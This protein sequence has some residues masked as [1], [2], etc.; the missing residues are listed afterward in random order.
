MDKLESNI[1]QEE[2]IDLQEYA[3]TG[4]VPEK[5]KKY[6]FMIKN[7]QYEVNVDHMTGRELCLM[8]NLIPPEN[9]KLDM[10]IKGNIYKEIGL[11][12]IVWLTEPGLEKF[13]YISKDQTEG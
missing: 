11:D 10:K 2:I 6:K 7:K 1:T 8:A 9:Y 3:T 12:E 4:R 5:G 13:T